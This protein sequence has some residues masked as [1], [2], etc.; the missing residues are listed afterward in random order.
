MNREILKKPRFQTALFTL[1]YLAICFAVF[2]VSLRTAVILFTTFT[3]VMILEPWARFAQRYLK[4]KRSISLG[5]G[6]TV[7]FAGLVLL[8]VFLTT[9][10]AKEASKFF[11]ILRDFFPSVQEAEITSFEVNANI[12][13]LLSDE[14]LL[15]KLSAEEIE[16]LDLVSRDLK[17]YYSNLLKPM[18]SD[19]GNLEKDLSLL[20]ESLK[21][22]SDYLVIIGSSN[23]RQPLYDE[24][25]GIVSK[26]LNPEVAESLSANVMENV[27]LVQSQELWKDVVEYF[28]PKNIDPARRRATY[29][30]VR[31]FL[32]QVQ[33]SLMKFLPG[34]LE[35]VPSFVT[36]AGLVLFFTIVGAIYLS[37]YFL[38]VK[39]FIPKFYPKKVRGTA[40]S[41]L[42]DTYKNLERYVISVVLL[43]LIVGIVVGI[44][45]QSMGLKYSLLMGLWAAFTNLIPIV[46]VPLEFVPLVLLAVS[47]QNLVLVLVLLIILAIVHA[48][49]FIL[50]LV[51]MKGYNRINPVIII[52]MILVAGQLLGLFGAII[53]VP[54]AIILKMMWIHFFSPMLEEED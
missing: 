48:A 15:E 2:S 3:V 34:I 9:P 39:E 25:N 26:Y 30:S 10:V 21:E 36:S 52:L 40:L 42:S 8:I 54:F 45:V 44:V 6:L 49:A 43:A 38:S 27:M 5:I 33:N 37:Y 31:N 1:F 11:S 41:F 22:R 7:I 24:I 28:M 4:L 47:T 12:D 18:P 35:K 19:A 23:R 46:G 13:R 20:E 16:S 50:F 53:A 14:D 32:I 17:D 29:E 51:F